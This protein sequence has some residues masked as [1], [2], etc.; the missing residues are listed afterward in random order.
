MT[1]QLFDITAQR[2]LITG[3]SRGIGFALARGMGLAGAKVVINGRNKDALNTAVENLRSEGIDANGAAFDVTSSTDVTEA[4]GQIA[5][6]LGPIDTL[7]NNAGM[8]HRQALDQFPDA[9]WNQII[10]TNL[11]SAFFVSRAVAKQMIARKSGQIINICSVQSE[12]GRPSIAPY[13]ATKGALKMLTKGMAIDWGMHGIRAN[14]IGPGYFDTDLN[15]A[16]V[17]N[18]EFSGWLTKRTPLGRWGQVDE[19]VGAAI[20]LASK[21]STFVTG[22]VI[23]VDG[24]VTSSL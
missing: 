2:I 10:A 6:T 14:A 1:T 21:A 4:V 9:A 13:A 5:Q 23:Y 18:P 17:Q 7:I 15:A 24:G 8:Q 19:L 20:F 3:G 22:Q 16:L 11:S 12:L